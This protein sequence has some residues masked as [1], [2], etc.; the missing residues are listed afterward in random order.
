MGT[1]GSRRTDKGK[2]HMSKRF[3]S[4]LIAGALVSSVFTV[5]AAGAQEAPP[6]IPETGN[7]E[8]P[9]GD[10]NFINDQG[11]GGTVG[12][13]GDNSGGAT[14]GAGD[15]HKVWFTNTA[16]KVSAHILTTCPPPNSRFGLLYRVAVNDGCA[17]FTGFVP[18]VTYTGPQEAFI[19]VPPARCGADIPLVEGE[20]AVAPL[21]DGRG[22]TTLTFPLGS[23][24]ELS[25]GQ[26]LVAPVA[27]TRL[28]HGAQSPALYAPQVDN[29]KPGTDYA[30]ASGEP[31][32]EEPPPAEEPEPK[33][34]KE[35]KKCKKGK[36]KGKK[37][38]CK[39]GKGPKGG[40]PTEPAGCVPM[41]PS[42]GGAEAPITIVTDAATE[43]APIEIPIDAPAGTPLAPESVFH[44]LQV[45]T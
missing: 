43:E 1:R 42:E 35:K 41:T 6:T 36:G 2:L 9:V 22:I 25:I 13:Q 31:T 45:D 12:F 19:S 5:G 26:T 32:A 24:P 44:N 16:D 14:I 20:I 21:E 27:I 8:D 18:S 11:A 15:M 28:A 40:K 37:K 39:K 29:T 33:P 4:I 34:D 7:I 23:R 38:G 30:I 3:W 10:G 17:T